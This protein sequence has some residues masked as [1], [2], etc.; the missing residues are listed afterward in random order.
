MKENHL[1]SDL[2][3]DVKVEVSGDVAHCNKNID[4]LLRDK[5]SQLVNSQR[6]MNSETCITTDVDIN[7]MSLTGDSQFIGS[8]REINSETCNT[9]ELNYNGPETSLNSIGECVKVCLLAADSM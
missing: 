1:N 5:D 4:E 6:E 7:D 8:Q 9:N 2:S 3:R